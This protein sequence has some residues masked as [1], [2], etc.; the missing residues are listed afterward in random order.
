MKNRNTESA[1][2]MLVATADIAKKFS[3]WQ[4]R[5]EKSLL[6]VETDEA[7]EEIRARSKGWFSVMYI[8][9]ELAYLLSEKDDPVKRIETAN[10]L[11]PGF[12][13]Y[14]SVLLD[15]MSATEAAEIVEVL[16]HAWLSGNPPNNKQ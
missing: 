14:E 12:A 15:G 6:D 11:R 9:Q 8:A 5:L 10:D 7:S 13:I 1:Q 16:R 3:D 4:E 2:A